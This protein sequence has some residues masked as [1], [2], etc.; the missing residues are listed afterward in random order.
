MAEKYHISLRDLDDAV[1]A[2]K[3]E[4]EKEETERERIDTQELRDA[5]THAKEEIEK[6]KHE[7]VAYFME[8]L[9]VAYVKERIVS[10]RMKGYDQTEL[11]NEIYH[12]EHTLEYPYVQ[13]FHISSLFDVVLSSQKESIRD[14]IVSLINIDEISVTCQ[15]ECY[16]YNLTII[17]RWG[18]NRY[19][20]DVVYTHPNACIAFI[21]FIAIILAFFLGGIMNVT[22]KT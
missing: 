5:Q 11:I 2:K 4:A 12:V 9:T 6:V 16:M 18:L 13:D 21:P 14:R 20:P 17:L 22:F 10:A 7:M 1:R 3:L 15:G 8:K 19:L